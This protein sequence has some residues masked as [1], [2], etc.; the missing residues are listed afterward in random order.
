MISFATGRIN[1]CHQETKSGA[2]GKKVS[3]FC[4]AVQYLS[5]DFF[6]YRTIEVS[7]VNVCIGTSV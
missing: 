7:M 3:L 4:Y 6:L 1:F 2:I 5:R